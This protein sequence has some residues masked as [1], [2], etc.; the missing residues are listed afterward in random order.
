[1]KRLRYLVYGFQH[2]TENR[3][4]NTEYYKQLFVL[5]LDQLTLFADGFLVCFGERRW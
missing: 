2:M 3:K 4:P 1:M 5:L